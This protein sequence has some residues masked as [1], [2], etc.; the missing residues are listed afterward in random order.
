MRK[1]KIVENC[2]LIIGL[3]ALSFMVYSYGVGEI[4]NNIRSIGWRFVWILLIWLITYAMNAAAWQL[5]IC[6]DRQ[7]W[8]RIPFLYVLKL[9]ITGYAI[10]YTTPVGLM[11]GEPYRVMELRRF[12]GTG[13]A[14]SS[15]ILYSMMHI[16]SHI[17]FWLFSID[18]KSVV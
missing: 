4:W 16:F 7:M 8:R 13:K 12:V 6:E 10:N 2:F 14:T 18:R 15:V 3:A 1:S 5:I 11:G 17:L 9:T